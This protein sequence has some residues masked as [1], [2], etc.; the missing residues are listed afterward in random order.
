PDP[1]DTNVPNTYTLTYSATGATNVTRTVVV[2]ATPVASFTVD[3]STITEGSMVNFDA[4]ASTA[5]SAITYNWDFGDGSPIQQTTNPTISHQYSSNVGSPFTA[6]LSIEDANGCTSATNASQE[7]TVNPATSPF[8]DLGALP[9]TVT[10]CQGA[11]FTDTVS[12]ED[13]NGNIIP[14]TTT[15]SPDPFDTNLPGT[16][17]LTYSAAGATDMTRTVV[18]NTTP[19]ASFNVDQLTITEGETVNF[20]ASASTASSAITY[21]WNFGDG[22]PIQTT[23]N[24]TVDHTYSTSAGSPFTT[25]L[26]IE[27]ADGCTNT[28]T[29]SQEIIVNVTG[30]ATVLINSAKN[31]SYVT[32][33]VQITIDI[34]ETNG[35]NGPYTAGYRNATGSFDLSN[36][37]SINVDTDISIGNNITNWTFIG[38]AAFDA[39]F[40]IY[41][42]NGAGEEIGSS[43]INIAVQTFTIN[44]IPD[45][46]PINAEV[47]NSVDFT[48]FIGE[49]NG[50]IGNQYNITINTDQGTDGTINAG[51][52]SST[53]TLTINNQSPG[54]PISISYI[55]TTATNHA[56]SVSV[57]PVSFNGL[58][59]NE[60]RNIN[61]TSTAFPFTFSASTVT[62]NPFLFFNNEIDINLNIT[63]AGPVGGGQHE[64]RF[65]GDLAGGQI[66]DQSNNTVSLNTWTSVNNSNLTVWKFRA[67]TSIGIADLNFEARNASGGTVTGNPQNINIKIIDFSIT[68]N[69]TTTITE[70]AGT[71]VTNLSVRIDPT[72]TS[73]IS[74][75]D[76]TIASDQADGIFNSGDTH[77]TTTVN[78][79]ASFN[80]NYTGTSVNLH[81]LSI[82]ATPVGQTEPIRTSAFRIDYVAGNQPPIA[83]NDSF[84]IQQNSSQNLLLVYAD[85]GSGIDEDP[86]NDDFIINQIPSNPSKGIT[87][88]QGDAINYVPTNGEFGNDTFTYNLEDINGNVSNDATV[89]VFINRPPTINPQSVTR[90]ISDRSG[91]LLISINSLTN[92][93]DGH[94]VLLNAVGTPSNNG[95]TAIIGTGQQTIVFSGNGGTWAT[96]TF[97]YQVSDGFG[98]TATGTVIVEFDPGTGPD[99]CDNCP[100]GTSCTNCD[101]CISPMQACPQAPPKEGRNPIKVEKVNKG[102]AK[103]EKQ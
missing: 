79:G 54:S 22:S 30:S 90:L 64:V 52:D 103:I 36:G 12:A 68:V 24:P 85:N 38:N 28:N 61:Y 51:G 63:P 45:T 27:D 72:D 4:S 58:S 6:T 80:F 15:S 76:L 74:A 32:E 10:L 25:T 75:Y 31:A 1:F 50:Q 49:V 35:G 91:T 81:N 57:V 7:I 73:F 62:V 97:T 55:G 29:A 39:S 94:T 71:Q 65:T 26:T 96:S 40:E 83:Q 84:I 9:A 102:K 43:T 59:R 78:G 18:V 67:G 19:V 99:P 56:I 37:T 48:L 66:L 101:I 93:P 16:Y 47:G 17:T 2:N 20:D 95:G 14:V 34:D 86:E 44:L 13:G 92:D 88:I 82:S 89:S 53:G 60:N 21:T 8:I 100:P 3:Q 5:S 87:A 69:P 42:K 46:D 23:T 33:N 11:I 77:I 41:V 98:G 70:T